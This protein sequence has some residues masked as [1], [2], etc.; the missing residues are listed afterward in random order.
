M[1]V[2]L[3][4]S[5]LL[6]A[7]LLCAT[8]SAAAFPGMAAGAQPPASHPD[9][10]MFYLIS[11][12]IAEHRGDFDFSTAAYLEVLKKH[13]QKDVA[14][15]A[16]RS[17]VASRS[18][19]SILEVSRKW[20]AFDPK[21]QPAHQALLANA[22]DR[23]DEAAAKKELDAMIALERDKAGWTASVLEALSRMNVDKAF[24]LKLIAPYEARYAK[25]ARVR[26]GSALLLAAA[27]RQEQACRFALDAQSRRPADANFVSKT[28]DL[29]YALAPE[30]TQKRLKAFLKK[31]P[32][33]TDVRLIY[34]RTLARTGQQKAALTEA[35]KALKNKHAT[36]IDRYAAG[37]LALEANAPEKALV[38]LKDYV[39]LMQKEGREDELEHSDAWMRIARLELDRGDFAAAAAD[40]ARVAEGPLAAQARLGRAQALAGAGRFEE[41]VA[42]LA[43]SAEAMPENKDLFAL[44]RVELAIDTNRRADAEKML[45]EYLDG[46]PSPDLRYDAAMFYER[47]GNKARTV[48]VLQDLLEDAPQHVQAANALGYI[49]ADEGINLP[50]ARALLET[51]FAREPLD[52][53][54]LDSMG[55]LCYRE[56][57]LEDAVDYV[58]QSLRRRFDPAVAEHLI[59]IL[60]RAGRKDEAQSLLTQLKAKS[61]KTDVKALADKLGLKVAQ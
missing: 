60:V 36:V 44:A 53:N 5:A 43:K 45:D 27:G 33:A 46:D 39:K 54:I 13:P 57:K 20:L 2:K 61:P 29:C 9:L 7:V 41:A 11:G 1:H 48:R 4:L 28:A 32:S 50:Q 14:E 35:Q 21:S 47:L 19:E 37:L 17:A 25:D 38:W 40:F 26:M 55:W 23:K 31:K 58:M 49:W 3:R 6:G 22:I 51:A 30:E 56:G 18:Q 34:G 10:S 42:F 24:A 8:Q 12:D 52:A 15:A 59:E 16:W